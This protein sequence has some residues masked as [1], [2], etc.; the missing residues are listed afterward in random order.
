MITSYP[1]T[2]GYAQPDPV[3]DSGMNTNNGP[4][5]AKGKEEVDL[6]STSC[7]SERL[8]SNLPL[9]RLKTTDIPYAPHPHSRLLASQLRGP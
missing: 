4:Q 2:I 8:P 3:S 5:L 6:I 1:K 9:A 7:Y